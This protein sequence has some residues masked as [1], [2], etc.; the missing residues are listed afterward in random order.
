MGKFS[1]QDGN[2]AVLEPK[3]EGQV[4]TEDVLGE[5]AELRAEVTQLKSGPG[6]TLTTVG[7]TPAAFSQKA[8]R[9]FLESKL[10]T[11]MYFTTQ[12][13]MMLSAIPDSRQQRATQP[14]QP[15]LEIVP[16]VQIVAERYKGV[17]SELKDDEKKPIFPWGWFDVAFHPE[18][19][20]KT[21]TIAEVCK[22]IEA[23]P[24]FAEEQIF[25]AESGQELLRDYYELHWET[26]SRKRARDEKRRSGIPGAH[27][28]G[29]TVG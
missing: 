19:K 22:A 12:F 11:T 17:G 5:L 24:R 9:E 28:K 6:V 2:T 29:G 18:I 10:P 4:S 20:K 13:K 23:S 21:F 3:V 27:K 16:G 14:G 1:K 26:E 7:D 8:I 25:T 15:V